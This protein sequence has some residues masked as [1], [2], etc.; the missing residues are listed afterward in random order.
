MDAF[1]Y[2]KELRNKHLAHD[3][4]DYTTC[5]PCA[6]I[7]LGGKSYKVEN[8][9]FIGTTAM[10]L[11]QSNFTNLFSLIAEAKNWVE[12]RHIKLTKAINDELE[13]MTLE[14]LLAHEE[15]HLSMPDLDRIDLPRENGT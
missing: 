8:V 14:D 5:I 6:S 4:N 1:K 10:T 9:G 3:E 7:N 13:A 2:F 12:E 11:D 15:A